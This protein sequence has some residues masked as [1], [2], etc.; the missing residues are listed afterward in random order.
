MAKKS[1][2][3][4]KAKNEGKFGAKAKAAGMSTQAY[5]AKEAHAP[6]VLGAEARFAKNIGGGSHAKAVRRKIA[7]H[8]KGH[9]HPST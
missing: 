6:G 4:I 8:G 7:N 3:H 2:I 5:A 9:G 1:G